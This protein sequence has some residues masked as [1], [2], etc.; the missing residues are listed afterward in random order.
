MDAILCQYLVFDLARNLAAN[1]AFD[2]ARNLAIF[3]SNAIFADSV[4]LAI[5]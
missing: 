5:L 3:A 4:I 1:F 2:L